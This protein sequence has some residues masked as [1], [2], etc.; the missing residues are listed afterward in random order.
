M[1]I[2]TKKNII[3]FS[4]FVL[5]FSILLC[6]C[7]DRSELKEI[8]VVMGVGVDKISGEE[9]F[10]VTVEFA[11]PKASGSSSDTISKSE[12]SILQVSKGKSFFDA[13][14]NFSKI[15]SVIM[16]FS[17]AKIV[18]LSKELCKSGISEIMDY[19]NRDRQ[20]RSTNWVLVAN[21]SA[22]EILESKI[23]NE[24]ITSTGIVN[25]MTKL[26]KNAS[27]IPVN[28]NDYIIESESESKSSFAPVI[29]VENSKDN[30]IGKIKIEK[31]AIFKNNRLIGLLTNEESKSL[32]WLSDTSKGHMVI[33]PFKSGEQNENVTI[34]VFKKSNKIIP[35]LTEDG[36]HIEID[37]TG[38]AE[39]KE[40][41]NININP[42]MIEKITYNTETM[43]KAQLIELIN[44]AQ[45]D[46]NTDFIG[47]S[48]KI[49]NNNPKAWLSMKKDWYEIFPY[50]KYDINFK[51]NVTNIGIIK[52]SATTNDTEVKNR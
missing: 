8:T 1:K 2:N 3:L 34:D 35:Y 44:K 17:H 4:I 14:E 29:E 23:A 45:K 19:L 49:Y 21:N 5:I 51:I 52:D 30:P 28:I 41:Q 39:L 33:I 15:N 20:F 47:F 48:K 13:I 46:F 26:K 22:K 37:C 7:L 6:G 32:L 10:L 24:N 43:L 18:V 38:Y 25:M 9:P 11:N 16:D 36:V 12:N 40:I 42:E 31:T 50:I 27:I